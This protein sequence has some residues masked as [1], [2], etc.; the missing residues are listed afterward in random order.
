MQKSGDDREVPPALNM[1]RKFPRVLKCFK[2]ELF[3]CLNREYVIRMYVSDRHCD[4][5]RSTK[6]WR[7]VDGFEVPKKL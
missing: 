5:D 7:F 4:R 2:E 3:W 6:I 1:V